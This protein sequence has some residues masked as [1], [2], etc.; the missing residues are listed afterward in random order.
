MTSIG[1]QSQAGPAGSPSHLPE[2]PFLPWISKTKSRRAVNQRHSP[3]Q[4]STNTLILM[5]T[6]IADSPVQREQSIRFLANATRILRRLRWIDQESDDQGR[7]WRAV[8][9]IK[10]SFCDVEGYVAQAVVIVG[11]GY[12]DGRENLHCSL[13]NGFITYSKPWDEDESE[14]QDPSHKWWWIGN[15]WRREGKEGWMMG[16]DLTFYSVRIEKA[17][18]ISIA[19]AFHL[20]EAKIPNVLFGGWLALRFA[21]YDTN[22]NEASFVIPDSSIPTAANILTA[23]GFNEPCTDDE[24]REAH[25]DGDQSLHVSPCVD[26]VAADAE[27]QF[28]PYE[29]FHPVPEV[30]FHLVDGD[31]FGDGFGEYLL[32]LYCKSNLLWWSGDG[33]LGVSTGFLAAAEYMDGDGAVIETA[34]VTKVTTHT[35]RSQNTARIPP[36]MDRLGGG[37]LPSL[38]PI[39][40]LSPDSFTDALIL[41][42]C[43]TIEDAES[44]YRWW[45]TMLGIMKSLEHERGKKIKVRSEFETACATFGPRDKHGGITDLLCLSR[46][47]AEKGELGPL[48]LPGNE[49]EEKGRKEGRWGWWFSWLY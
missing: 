24:C 46:A 29:R 37:A 22:P 9:R 23:A 16:F 20:D 5:I 45:G 1:G 19:M 40:F 26:C 18:A 3:A 27:M 43:R 4:S 41:L 35:L 2:N 13:A 30:H 42:F 44:L 17:S 34:T 11:E 7:Q 31:G 12:G 14:G 48:P 21:G 28:R 39:Q 47:L 36:Y 10:D 32:S 49:L 6:T 15:G 8:L 25:V 33:E 38:Y